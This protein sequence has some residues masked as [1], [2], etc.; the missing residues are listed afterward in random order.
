MRSLFSLGLGGASILALG[1]AFMALQDIYHQEADLTLEWQ[2]V[3][4]SM[5]MITAFHAVAIPALWK[6]TKTFS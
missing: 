5:L 4:I 2:I 3:R 6:K 1:A